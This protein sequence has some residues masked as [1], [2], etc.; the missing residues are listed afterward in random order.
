MKGR[1]F[2]MNDIDEQR[3]ALITGAANGIGR[4]TAHELSRVGYAIAAF[5]LQGDEAQTLAETLSGDGG[6]ALAVMGNVADADDVQEAI[7]QIDNRWGRLD[8]V[9]ANAGINGVWAPLEELEPEEFDRTINVNLRGTF[10]TVKYALPLLRKRGGS[11]VVTS[12]VNGNR[13]FSNTGATAY[14]CSKAGQ[15]AFVRMI[16]LELAEDEIR[17]NSICPGPVQTQIG[18]RT[19]KRRTKQAGPPVEYPKGTVPLTD[20]DPA[21]P[22]EVA[23]LVR[24][25]AGGE[26]GYI[27]GA[28]VY[29]DGAESLLQG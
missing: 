26:S 3:V 24:F 14:A 8:V 2:P 6:D 12:S 22:E 27:S 13:V 4:A 9:F 19:E 20:G 23:K 29:I 7:R 17:V 10:L 1:E 28:N 16:A 5:D 11:I 15:V 18:R 21:R 25:L